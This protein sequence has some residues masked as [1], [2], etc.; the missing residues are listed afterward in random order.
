MELEKIVKKQQELEAARIADI[1]KREAAV[2]AREEADRQRALKH[3]AQKK[4]A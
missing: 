3:E 2:K 4:Q 1:K